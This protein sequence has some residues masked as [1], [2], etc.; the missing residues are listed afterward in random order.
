MKIWIDDVRTAPAGYTWCKS[1]NEAKRAIEKAE[2][3]GEII[4]VEYIRRI[5]WD[6]RI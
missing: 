2:K 6:A 3:A 1:V 5:Q 4:H